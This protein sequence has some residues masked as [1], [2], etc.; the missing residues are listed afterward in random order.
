MSNTIVTAQN[1]ASRSR[2]PMQWR[3]TILSNRAARTEN[4]AS[5]YVRIDD[6]HQI[7]A[8]PYSTF[9]FSAQVGSF[10]NELPSATVTQP[11]TSILQPGH[12]KVTSPAPKMA[13]A[14]KSENQLSA[15][16]AQAA[17]DIRAPLHAAQEILA[18]A[19]MMVESD[20]LLTR[21]DLHLLNSA[22]TRLQL[23][24]R[25]ISKVLRDRGDDVQLPI[26]LCKRFYPHQLRAIV[27][28]RLH[29]MAL[30]SKVKL[31]WIGWDRALPRLYLDPAQLGRVIVALVADAIQFN[32]DGGTVNIRVAWQANVTQR[33]VITIEDEARE[34]S[35]NALK[36]LNS[37]ENDLSLGVDNELSQVKKLLK[38]LG[39]SVSAQLS[40]AGGTLLRITLPVDDQLLLVRS[41]LQERAEEEQVRQSSQHIDRNAIFLHAIRAKVDDLTTAD[42]QLQCLAGRGDL[43]YRVAADRWLWLALAHGNSDNSR[44]EA[45]VRQL[46]K[47]AGNGPQLWRCHLAGSWR[48]VSL[49]KLYSSAEHRQLLPQLSRQ[50]AAKFNEFG[51]NRIPPIVELDPKAIMSAIDSQARQASK[52]AISRVDNSSTLRSHTNTNVARNNQPKSS[53]V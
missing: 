39:G 5:H 12:S 49:D 53:M 45:A 1:S 4:T 15:A 47:A 14:P 20:G 16:F 48:Q 10:S 30:A 46:S 7:V 3:F 35:A 13:L 32:R 2:A 6:R 33:L 41:W 28:P 51:L 26:S 36:F 11:F 34:L 19:T 8:A 50:I 9:S 44:A 27:Q 24:S 29:G 17:D 40:T 22:N 38:N 37:A 25:R 18:K 43:V 21:S 23:A 52:A 31:N 42:I